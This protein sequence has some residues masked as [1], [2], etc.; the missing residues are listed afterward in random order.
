[1]EAVFHLGFKVFQSCGCTCQSHVTSLNGTR[2]FGRKFTCKFLLMTMSTVCGVFGSFR[3]VVIH[4]DSRVKIII[5]IKMTYKPPHS[6][7]Q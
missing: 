1:M 7:E 3:Q 5:K 2:P 4:P 6:W